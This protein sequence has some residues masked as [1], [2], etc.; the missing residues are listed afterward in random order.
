MTLDY[1][2]I[3]K[4]GSERAVADLAVK[5]VEDVPESFRDLLDL[6]FLEE[7][8]LS[9]RS[10]RVIQLYC[11]KYPEAIYPFLDE[12]VEK[13]LR[14]QIKGVR[15]NF[16]KI[17]AEY[18]DLER[19]IDPGQL[20]NTCFTWLIDARLTPAVRIHSMGVIYKLGLKNPELHHELKAIIEIISE[21]GEP[22]I[23]NCA[24]KMLR[25]IMTT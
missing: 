9:M 17:F 2:T 15:H 7:Y 8:P 10:A 19:I 13:T 18:I 16:L 12:A 6:C 22:S 25:K 21:E 11:K 24:G 3:L 1:R 5:A 20:L 14:S 4:M 23:K